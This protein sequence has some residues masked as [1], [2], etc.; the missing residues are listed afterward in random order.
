ML[1]FS[2]LDWSPDM[3]PIK[4]EPSSLEPKKWKYEYET[5][6]V[7]YFLWCLFD[8]NYDDENHEMEAFKPKWV[9]PNDIIYGVNSLRLVALHISLCY[10]IF[11]KSH[12][13]FLLFFRMKEAETFNS[14]DNRLRCIFLQNHYTLLTILL[15][16][17]NLSCH[18]MLSS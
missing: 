13:S 16:F 5:S 9:N 8:K 2:F 18:V 7:F 11:I 15:F 17:L 3:G 1:F 10:L 14:V 12:F 4:P 6:A